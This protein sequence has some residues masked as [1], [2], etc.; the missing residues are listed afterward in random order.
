MVKYITVEDAYKLYLDDNY[1]N[2]MPFESTHEPDFVHL[3]SLRGLEVVEYG[4]EFDGE[5]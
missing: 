4:S 1:F 3:L 5:E 2:I